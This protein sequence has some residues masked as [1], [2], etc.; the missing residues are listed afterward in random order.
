MKIL[1]V[2]PLLESGTCLHRMIALKDLGHE[3]FPVDTEP[4]HVQHKQKL[5]FYRVRQK[6]FGP[7]DLAEANKQICHLIKKDSFDV[8]WVDKGI[9][10]KAE[11]LKKIKEESSRTILVHYNPDDPFGAVKPGWKTFLKSAPLYDVH[12]VFRE[13]NLLEYKKIGC[14]KVFRLY[15][16]Y[17]PCLHRP[18]NITKEDR[19]KLGGPVGFIGTYEKER[20]QSMYFLAQNEIPIR[21]WGNDWTRRCYLQHS[22]LKV[23][24]KALWADDF[25]K[26]ICSFDI[27]L[28]FL[29]KINRDLQTT[30]SIEI[31]AC[32]GFMLAE[33]T[34]EHLELFKEGEEAEFFS[35]DE[36][37]LAKVQYY[38]EHEDQRK[39]IA[40][41][42]RRRCLTSG[43]SHH[44]RL[45]HML[46]QVE[47][48]CL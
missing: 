3:I 15:S 25:A 4:R 47:K 45:R 11:T 10:I 48:L 31:P 29:R 43:Y 26:S 18:I 39:A 17:D 46:E 6:L 30:R 2:G 14:K 1:Y 16:G 24:G 41:A 27:N 20:A 28:A 22:N 19:L 44:D 42:G 21:I 12:F 37:L 33:R 32:G 8:I 34:N 23:E 38:L 5:F 7:W 40:Q 36:E 35:S 13:Q 9:T